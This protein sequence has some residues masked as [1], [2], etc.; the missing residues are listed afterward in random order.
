MIKM[1]KHP[2]AQRPLSIAIKRESRSYKNREKPEIL[3]GPEEP[4]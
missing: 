2:L 4:R 1:K 3:K